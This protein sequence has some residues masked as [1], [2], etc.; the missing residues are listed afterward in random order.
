[1]NHNH[2]VEFEDE[3]YLTAEMV[4]DRGDALTLSLGHQTVMADADAVERVERI[5]QRSWSGDRETLELASRETISG[6]VHARGIAL[7]LSR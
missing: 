1:M 2:Y 4:E 6:P 5:E 3:S 7:E